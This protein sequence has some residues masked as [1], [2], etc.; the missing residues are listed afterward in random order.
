MKTFS[1]PGLN[2]RDPQQGK[3]PFMKDMECIKQEASARSR[4]SEKDK[5]SGERKTKMA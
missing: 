5:I 2:N 1:D 4:K 3:H